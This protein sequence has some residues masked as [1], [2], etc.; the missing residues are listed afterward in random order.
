[1]SEV[2]ES[3]ETP[4]NEKVDVN[5]AN[6]AMNPFTPSLHV[7]ITDIEMPFMSMVFFMIKWAFATIPAL[8]IIWIV[9]MVVGA[10]FRGITAELSV[11]FNQR[12]KN[13]AL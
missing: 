1:M 9:I 13:I 4:K 7:K 5:I 2:Q 3:K 8:I 10:I 6:V 11:P 12:H